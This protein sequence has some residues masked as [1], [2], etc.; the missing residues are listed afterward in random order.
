MSRAKR[1]CLIAFAVVAAL[2]VAFA[3][4]LVIYSVQ[5]NKT[6][7]VSEYVVSHDD[8]P[9]TFDGKRIVQLSD[10]HNADFGGELTALVRSLA[11]DILVITGDWI[12][13]DDTDISVAKEQAKA[14]VGIAPIYYVAG[15]HEARSSL[16]AELN[17]YLRDI[18]ITVLDGEA[19]LWE[20][21]GETVQLVGIFDPEY[22]THLWRDFA[23]LVQED[24][25]TVLLFHRPEYLEEAAQFGA[26]LILSGHTHGGQI[27]LP[28]IGA[29]YAPNQGLFPTYDVG[30]F[31]TDDT[32]M[33]VSEG[34]GVS[35]YMRILAPPEVVVVTLKHTVSWEAFE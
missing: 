33:I 2:C 35:A 13:K 7:R 1:I 15:N 29:L 19:V 18:G 3:A 25:Y 5:Q 11:P 6:I 31:E 32:T 21:N 12:S 27:R 4:G 30:R 10:L 28:L 8:I 24:R 17:T 23:P 20:E 22:S 9:V 26:D 14:L 34:L 16:W